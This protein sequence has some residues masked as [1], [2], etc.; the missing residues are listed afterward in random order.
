M[1]P[2]ITSQGF[3]VFNENNACTPNLNLFKFAYEKTNDANESE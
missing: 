2:G 3:F 1:S